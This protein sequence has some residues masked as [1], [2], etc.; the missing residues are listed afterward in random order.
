MDVNKT[1]WQLP[2]AAIIHLVIFHSDW[3]LSLLLPQ[4]PYF[5]SFVDILFNTSP[6]CQRKEK[7]ERGRGR[8]GTKYIIIYLNEWKLKWMNKL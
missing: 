1:P 6:Q 3:W 7:K 8:R 4:T 5:S 2:N